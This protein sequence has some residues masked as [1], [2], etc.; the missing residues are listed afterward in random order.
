MT[1]R[2]DRRSFLARGAV[3]G[4][5]VAAATAGGGLLAACGS[6]SSSSSSSTSGGTRPSGI[7]T[8]TPKRGGQMVFGTEAE[9]NGFNPTA[10]TFDASGIMYARTVFDPLAIL[11]ADGTVQPYLAQSISS[12]S[13]GTVW[14]ITM[15][16]NVVF[17][18]GAPCDAA[19]VAT[20]FHLAIASLLEGSALT[21][22][23]SVSVTDPL[24]V[25]VTMKTP[26]VP[27]DYYLTGGV[28]GQIAYVAEPKWLA[29]GQESNP[30]GTGPFIFQEWTPNNHVSFTRNPHYW[31]NGLPY[32]DSVTYK[33]IPDTQQLI[34]SLS[35]GVIDM[36]HT[37]SS[38]AVGALRANHSY[39]Y[40]DDSEHVLGEPDMRCLMLNLSKPP[41]DNL[42]VR[43]AAAMAV[44]SK[45]Y[46][47]VIDYGL[48]PP[49]N[50]PF[51][52]GSPYYV[53][54]NGYP[55][56]NPTKAAQLLKEVEAEQGHP[57]TM[58]ITHVSDPE[59]TREAEFLQQQ[60]QTA[61]FQVSLSPIQQNVEITSA[62]EGQFQS[63][64]WRQ[65]G[66][67]DPDMNYIFW[68]PTT[69]NSALSINMTHN[70]DPS[71]EEALLKGRQSTDPATRAAAY[72]Q[73]SRLMAQDLPYIWTD[74]TVWAAAASSRL[75]NWLG[76]KAPNG[77][78]AAGFI[79]GDIWPTQIWMNS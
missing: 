47:E 39:S 1:D 20:N 11:G 27:F 72:Q 63:I 50:G 78:A 59:T 37:S 10:G 43:Q 73:V 25:V 12:N 62:L 14:T 67:V 66:A 18:N 68:S 38:Y 51:A 69:V 15:R 74:R 71:M 49:T 2:I 76:P 61:G 29:S 30:V 35:S 19:A 17:H 22:I 45:A 70:M 48:C 55:A 60:L 23:A 9:E 64:V 44:S 7:S 4:A 57:V 28:G 46:A 40:V 52:V 54:D 32:L 21:S 36:M 6:S 13:D 8:A 34:Q 3:V 56:F 5:G 75:Q 26:W 53:A 31:L 58:S 77:Q 65:F 79:S 42:K 24:T 41:F 16:P 33:P